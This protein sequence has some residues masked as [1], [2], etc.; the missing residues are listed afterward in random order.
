MATESSEPRIGLILKLAGVCLVTLIAV[1][2]LL[3]AYYDRMAKAEELRKIGAPEALVN[4]R[5]D[6]KTRLTSGQMPIDQAMKALTDKGR[7]AVSPA[8]APTVSKDV[9]PL[10]GWAKL[11][12]DVPPEMTAPPPP[13]IEAAPAVAGDAGA[14]AAGKPDGGPAPKGHPA[15][16]K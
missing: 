13:P 6:E 15:K 8:I 2:L 16:G 5:A 1:H 12:V 11:P 14:A 3:G 7:M 9:A 10:Q 4:L